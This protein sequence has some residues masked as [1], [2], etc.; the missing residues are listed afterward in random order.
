[1]KSGSL[2]GL[3]AQIHWHTKIVWIVELNKNN[4]MDKNV[5]SKSY[6]SNVSRALRLHFNVKDC[7]I[8]IFPGLTL[9]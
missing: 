5:L 6:S 2:I 4:K 3:C 9:L 1:M 7:K 8:R